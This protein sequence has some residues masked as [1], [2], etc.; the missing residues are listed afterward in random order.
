MARLAAKEVGQAG[1]VRVALRSMQAR[2]VCWCWDGR[3][4]GATHANRHALRMCVRMARTRI[5]HY[6]EVDVLAH[7]HVG[8]WFVPVCVV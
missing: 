3:Q 2:S 8:L 6:I 4:D 5:T 7:V 1:P